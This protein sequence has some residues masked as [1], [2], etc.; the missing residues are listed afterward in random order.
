MR[1][2]LSNPS[3]PNV[4]RLRDV[5]SVLPGVFSVSRPLP[6]DPGEPTPMVTVRW[7]SSPA[8][9]LS[10][11]HI[12]RVSDL[13][14]DRYRV[15]EGDVLVPSRS[16]S[17]R[18]A[19][20]PRK[21]NGEVF[22]STLLAVRCSDRVL[23]ELL[24]AYLTHPTG[25]AH[26]VTASQSGTAQMN[27]TAAALGEIPVPI[28]PLDQQRQLAELLAAANLIHQSAREAA[29]LRRKIALDLVIS[30]MTGKTPAHA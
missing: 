21:L 18:V 29:D 23:P 30:R 3:L 22:N 5:A 19:V 15:H 16:T 26:L 17:I 13:R 12:A 9:P 11:L 27:L 28:V 24:A 25:A 1:V 20:A 2:P 14:A 7:L 10:M 6:G 4:A 8:E